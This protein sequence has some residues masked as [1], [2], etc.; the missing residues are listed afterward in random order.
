MREREKE[1]MGDS[2]F[3]CSEYDDM[4]DLTSNETDSWEMDHS[5]NTEDVTANGK[6]LGEVETFGIDGI[7]GRHITEY[8]EQRRPKVGMLPNCF[9]WGGVYKHRCGTISW[10]FRKPEKVNARWC[11]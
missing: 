10:I 4:V 9:L 2:K 3:L 5:Y 11:F 7:H 6:Y 1:S 8:Y